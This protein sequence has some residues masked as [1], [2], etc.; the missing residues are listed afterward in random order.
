MNNR[1]SSHSYH[2]DNELLI[3]TEQD[4]IG[5]DEMEAIEWFEHDE[6]VAAQMLLEWSTY[7]S[8]DEIPS[9][10]EPLVSG[11]KEATNCVTERILDAVRWT[12]DEELNF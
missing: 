11:R 5:D 4:K 3:Q 10:Q 9:S 1:S 2:P 6:R 12:V 7:T 8:V